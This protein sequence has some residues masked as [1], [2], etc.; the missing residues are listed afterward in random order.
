MSQTS[1]RSGIGILLVEGFKQGGRGGADLFVLEWT[2]IER[3]GAAQHFFGKRSLLLGRQVFEGVEQGRG[4]AGHVSKVANAR[5]IGL[6][7]GTSA[8]PG[9]GRDFLLQPARECRH[10]KRTTARGQYTSRVNSAPPGG[11]RCNPSA[12]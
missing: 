2:G 8:D 1:P 3:Q 7:P 9:S 11:S 12:R 6:F 5:V 4:L 10:K